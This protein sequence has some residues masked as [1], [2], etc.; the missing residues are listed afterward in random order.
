[1]Q[2]TANTTTLRDLIVSALSRI[3]SAFRRDNSVSTPA[4]CLMVDGVMLGAY[5]SPD[6]VE[7]ARARL[8]CSAREASSVYDEDGNCLSR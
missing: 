3:A 6:A 4:Y 1:M 2:Y 5:S 8:S 7:S